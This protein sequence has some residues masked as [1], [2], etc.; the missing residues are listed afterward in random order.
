LTAPTAAT[1]R[2]IGPLVL[3]AVLVLA[4]TA[5]TAKSAQERKADVTP[6]Q[7]RAQVHKA[8]T[9]TWAQLKPIGLWVHHDQGRYSNC[10][11]QGGWVSY[12]VDVRLDPTPNAPDRPL[13]DKLQKSLTQ[14]GW[15]IEGIRQDGPDRRILRAWQGKLMMRLFEYRSAPYLLWDIVGHCVEVGKERDGDYLNASQIDHYILTGGIKPKPP[16]G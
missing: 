10:V 5:C 4:A 6:E 13:V 3:L 9:D 12:L 7:D 15:T 8:L 11:D 16:A 2:R 1:M 14:A